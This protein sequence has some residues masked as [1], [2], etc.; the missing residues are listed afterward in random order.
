MSYS[1][2]NP[3]ISQHKVQPYDEQAR[4]KHVRHGF[5]HQKVMTHSLKVLME[6]RVCF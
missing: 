5:S 1:A 3:Q 4:I 2:R 6:T